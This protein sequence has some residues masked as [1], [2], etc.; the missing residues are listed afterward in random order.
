MDMFGEF[1]LQALG[2]KDYLGENCLFECARNGNESIFKWFMG[3]NDFFKARGTQNYKG[4]T[5]EHIVCMTRQHAIVDEINPRPDT[6]DYYGSL[7]LYYS[8]Q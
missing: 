1:K 2:M 6:T 8:L 4:R 7:P 5:I 3:T